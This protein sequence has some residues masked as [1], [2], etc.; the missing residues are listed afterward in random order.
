MP[1]SGFKTGDSVLTPSGAKATV[2]RVSTKG[3]EMVTVR[4]DLGA[5]YN[6]TFRAAALRFA[7]PPDVLRAIDQGVWEEA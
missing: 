5:G 4:Y 1:V 6:R 7:M 3:A 2:V